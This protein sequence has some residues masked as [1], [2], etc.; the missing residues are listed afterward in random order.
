MAVITIFIFIIFVF[1]IANYFQQIITVYIVI[2]LFI[3]A[4]VIIIVIIGKSNSLD[5]KINKSSYKNNNV[6]IIIKMT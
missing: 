5:E 4:I 3:I 2:Y 6:T 1:T